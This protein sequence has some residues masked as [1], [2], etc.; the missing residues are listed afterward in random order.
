VPLF[1]DCT[2]PSNSALATRDLEN[3]IVIPCRNRARF[4]RFSPR[5]SGEIALQ[6]TL[7]E[8]EG[9]LAPSPGYRPD[10]SARRLILA[11]TALASDT[12]RDIEI[13][14]G[15]PLM[16][17]FGSLASIWLLGCIVLPQRGFQIACDWQ[18]SGSMHFRKLGR[19]KLWYRIGG[20]LFGRSN[21]SQP[22]C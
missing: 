16:P 2:Q 20:I 11:G 6:S 15:K 13:G 22:A 8:H 10:A 9:G 5:Q 21:P 4:F 14:G 12:H 1:R 7:K 17:H 18:S 19:H 3:A